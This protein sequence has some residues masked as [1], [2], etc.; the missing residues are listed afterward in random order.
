MRTAQTEGFSVNS[1][2][3][4]YKKKEKEKTR[5]TCRRRLRPGVCHLSQRT[6]VEPQKL[7][8]QKGYLPQKLR[9]EPAPA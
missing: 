7:K 9:K 3:C 6:I 1:S 2:A 8:Q 4:A 5:D